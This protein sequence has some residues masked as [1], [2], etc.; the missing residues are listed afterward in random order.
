MSGDVHV[1]FCEGLGVRFPRAT[2]RVVTCRTRVEAE[3]ALTEATQILSTLGVV[4]N[5]E[6][7]RIAHVRHGFEFLGYKIKRGSRPLR[8][9]QDR[10]RCGVRQGGLYA[11]PRQK[12]ITHFKDQI[13]NRTRRKAPPTTQQ[14]IQEINPVIRGWG[15][16]YCRSHVRKLF[17]Q[18]DRWIQ[19]RLWSHR[20][21]R[22]RCTG[23]KTLPPSR[24]YGELGLV[25]LVSLVPSRG[26]R[27][28]RTFVKAGCGKTARPV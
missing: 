14:L 9:S 6:K 24:L 16:Y 20:Y 19:R 18:L 11:Y 28:G 12:S 25:N 8:L 10:I 5:Q 17:N 7:T 22:W 27:S 15:L 3:R 23:W 2:R 26:I 4:L 1:R 21:K 13:R